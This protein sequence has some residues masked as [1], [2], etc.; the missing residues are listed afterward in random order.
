MAA[1]PSYPSWWEIIG[2]SSL[3]AA[4]VAAILTMIREYYLERHKFKDKKPLT[5]LRNKSASTVNCSILL[6]AEGL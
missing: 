2:V 3:V 4:G 6:E 1:E 5:I